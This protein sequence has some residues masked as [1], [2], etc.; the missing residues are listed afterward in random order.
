MAAKPKKAEFHEIRDHFLAC[1]L[2]LCSNRKYATDYQE[3]INTCG[4][5]VMQKTG[6]DLRSAQ[7]IRDLATVQTKLVSAGAPEAHQVED[8]VHAFQDKWDIAAPVSPTLAKTVQAQRSKPIET[9]HD[10]REWCLDFAVMGRVDDSQKRKTS[11]Q[12]FVGNYQK[13]REQALELRKQS[14]LYEWLSEQDSELMTIGVDLPVPQDSITPK[15]FCPG[16]R[17]RYVASGGHLAIEP[18][19]ESDEYTIARWVI[20]NML[21][22]ELQDRT[23]NE[24]YRMCCGGEPSE[25]RLK[26]LRGNPRG[27]HLD[28]SRI[29][30]ELRVFKLRR[31][32]HPFSRIART[33]YP[34]DFCESKSEHAQESKVQAQYRHVQRLIANGLQIRRPRLPDAESQ[35][36]AVQ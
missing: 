22:E 35:L 9:L 21:V 23:G 28:L 2:L 4:P 14:G 29:Q 17:V 5:A 3:F 10:L 11:I 36:T 25:G 31:A 18:V 27:A 7:G 1:F 15:R 19:H 33:V 6:L 32:K 34:A 24:L 16:D 20:F 30:Q 8:W 26:E 12:V 13:E